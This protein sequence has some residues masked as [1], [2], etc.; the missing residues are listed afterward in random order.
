M[1]SLECDR[2]PWQVWMFDELC[3]IRGS[4][5]RPPQCRGSPRCS[6]ILW[7]VLSEDRHRLLSDDCVMWTKLQQ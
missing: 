4:P 1:G 5:I 3:I 6:D 7:I 2:S